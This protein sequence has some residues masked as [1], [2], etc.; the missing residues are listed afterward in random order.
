MKTARGRQAEGLT[1]MLVILA[2]TVSRT[3]SSRFYQDFLYQL[4]QALPSVMIADQVYL[5][6]NLISFHP[7][8]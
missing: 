2:S 7:I 4:F 8:A 3:Y 1:S 5:S 6:G